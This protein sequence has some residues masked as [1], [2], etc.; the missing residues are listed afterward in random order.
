MINKY[1]LA[2]P[3]TILNLLILAKFY[4]WM[5]FGA[6]YSN[7]Y[8]S[9]TSAF[10][11]PSFRDFEM[12]MQ[13]LYYAISWSPLLVSISFIVYVLISYAIALLL[14]MFLIWIFTKQRPKK[15]VE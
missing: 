5:I 2:I 1:R 9:M 15:G 13:S 11:A 3:V 8:S 14:A 6:I 7:D 12:L 4:N 10:L